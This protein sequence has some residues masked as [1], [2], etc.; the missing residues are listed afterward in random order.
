MQK[1]VKKINK[2]SLWNKNKQ[3]NEFLNKKF[4]KI[5]IKTKCFNI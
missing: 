4:K 1:N 5:K 2:P 3:I